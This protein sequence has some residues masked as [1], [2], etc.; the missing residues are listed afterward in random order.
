MNNYFFCNDLQD[1]AKPLSQNILLIIKEIL[2]SSLPLRPNDSFAETLVKYIRSVW[3][4]VRRKDPDETIKT[5]TRETLKTAARQERTRRESG[6]ALLCELLERGANLALQKFDQ[7][8]ELAVRAVHV[9]GTA[10]AAAGGIAGAVIGA[11]YPGTVGMIIGGL[12]GA[13]SSN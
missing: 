12:V 10:G 9:D 5:I 6:Q 1:I 11:L 7:Y 3:R 8:Y 4:K 2:S 13:L